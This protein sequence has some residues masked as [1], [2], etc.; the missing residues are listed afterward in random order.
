MFRAPRPLHATMSGLASRI[1]SNKA[2]FGSANRRKSGLMA[3]RAAAQGVSALM[4]NM[5]DRVPEIVDNISVESMPSHL[6][7]NN[8]MHKSVVQTFFNSVDVDGSG[9]IS[10]PE[11]INALRVIGDRLGRRFRRKDSM[12]LFSLLDVNSDGSID[13][14]EMFEGICRLNDRHL[15]A[16]CYAVDAC[17]M[18]EEAS[19]NELRGITAFQSL[20]DSIISETDKVLQSEYEK[21][22]KRN[23]KLKQSYEELENEKQKHANQAA[24]LEGEVEM[25]HAKHAEAVRVADEN[26]ILERSSSQLQSQIL[27]ADV[28]MAEYKARQKELE[29]TTVSAADF[30]ELKEDVEDLEEENHKLLKDRE[31]LQN[32][33]DA[34]NRFKGSQEQVKKEYETKLA[35]REHLL[36]DLNNDREKLR[37]KSRRDRQDAARARKL[38]TGKSYIGRGK[39]SGV[40]YDEDYH[41]FTQEEAMELERQVAILKAQLTA[42]APEVQELRN[43][44]RD[45]VRKL[46]KS[47][48]QTSSQEKHINAQQ[49]H[50][51]IMQAKINKQEEDIQRLQ[52][53]LLGRASGDGSRSNAGIGW[54]A[55]SVQKEIQFLKRELAVARDMISPIADLN[56]RLLAKLDRL[57]LENMRVR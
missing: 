4:Q 11:F 57:Q 28:K 26:R 21:L 45:L 22:L 53:Q 6:D 17:I 51:K 18:H 3:F 8:K 41:Q 38:A 1:R 7:V 40:E 25:L 34:L 31:R 33:V 30:Q 54:Q 35:A 13:A 15:I 43:E 32:M 20:R 23:K 55:D 2:K 50:K 47:N 9:E 16:V 39:I 10:V 44:K 5:K 19:D 56:K 48:A 42:M 14:D 12:S 24:I 29:A 36:Q 49:V 37:L 27:E 46:E 52:H